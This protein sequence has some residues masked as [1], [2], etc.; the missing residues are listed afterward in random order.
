[1]WYLIG[2]P[3]RAWT[4]WRVPSG[5]G[6][7]TLTLTTPTLSTWQLLTPRFTRCNVTRLGNER[8]SSN[9]RCPHGFAA[10]TVMTRPFGLTF[11][12]KTTGAFRGGTGKSAPEPPQAEIASTRTPAAI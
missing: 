1:M 12:G 8:A 9:G 6:S 3:F 11:T 5:R 10:R 4:R 2:L 7:L